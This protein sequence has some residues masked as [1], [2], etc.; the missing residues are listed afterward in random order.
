MGALVNPGLVLIGI[1]AKIGDQFSGIGEFG[2]IL[3]F[4]Q[5]GNACD[6]PYTWDRE[7][8]RVQFCAE[9]FY[10]FVDLGKLFLEHFDLLDQK[11]DIEFCRRAVDLVLMVHPLNL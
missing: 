11:A 5:Q 6:C 7:D 10:F 2:D 3:A 4:A 9:L 1:H 8:R